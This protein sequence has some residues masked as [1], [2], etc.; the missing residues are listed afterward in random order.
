M[1]S[2]VDYYMSYTFSL[3]TMTINY[4]IFIL[5]EK[6]KKAYFNKVKF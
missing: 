1:P 2:K 3:E 5:L 6:Y 4:G